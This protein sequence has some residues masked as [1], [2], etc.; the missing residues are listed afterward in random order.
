M[1]K[2]TRDYEE[3]KMILQNAVDDDYYKSKMK[4]ARLRA[5]FVTGLATVA[6]TTVGLATGD[7]TFGVLTF[8]SV[9][10]LLMPLVV[11][12]LAL[13][14]TKR[15]IKSGSYFEDNSIGTVI[16]NANDYV[17]EYNEYEQQKENGG[18]SK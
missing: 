17:F 6:A 9:H 13:A 5:L 12:Y 18:K 11:P 4:P 1:L 2:K 3:A 8:P 7:A 10:A 16:N 14:S 15:K